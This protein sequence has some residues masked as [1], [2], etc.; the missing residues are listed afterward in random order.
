MS[1]DPRSHSLL[2]VLVLIAITAAAIASSGC[3]EDA[4]TRTVDFSNTIH[5]ARPDTGSGTQ[6]PLRVAVAAMVS[7]RETFVYYRQ[8][9]DYLGRQLGRKVQLIQR[10][11]YLE[12]NELLGSGRIDMA[13]ICSGPYVTGKNKYGFELLAAPEVNGSHFYK[14]YLIVNVGSDI[15]SLEKLRGRTFAYTDPDS[16]S[17]RLVPN[18]WLAEMN[19]SPE[20]FFRRTIF[21]YSHDNSILA[22]AKGLVDGAA[23][24]SLIWEY[25]ERKNPRWTSRTRVVRKSEP[26]GI[27]PVVASSA[28]SPKL[29]ERIRRVFL[30]LANDDEGRGMLRHLMIDRFVQ[31]KD[32]WYDSIRRVLRFSAIERER[33]NGLSK[34]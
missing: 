6:K 22:V 1:Q 28:L 17:G 21:T 8:L 19:E 14:S 4:S 11:T 26:Y 3:V 25:Y 5:V 10:K 24:D 15:G 2:N 30:S 13:F 7:P 32:D 29:R 18:F 31:P 16:N 34:P 20:S 33:S 12:V 27:P 9:L 23:V